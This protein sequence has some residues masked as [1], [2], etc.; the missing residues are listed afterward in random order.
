M[1]S[2][3]ISG[4]DQG[5]RRL[6]LDALHHNVCLGVL[7]VKGAHI[8]DEVDTKLFFTRQTTRTPLI[9]ACLYDLLETH[10]VRQQLAEAIWIVTADWLRYALQ[11][12][13]LFAEITLEAI[14]HGIGNAEH[15]YHIC[16]V[17]R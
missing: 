1:L 7:S 16:D 4:I 3:I 8:T 5:M 12:Q 2:V 11:R 10:K 14:A 17:E 13:E 6:D 15:G 9:C